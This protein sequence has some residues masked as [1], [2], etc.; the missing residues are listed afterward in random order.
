L[1]DEY[2]QDLKMAE[3]GAL[4]EKAEVDAIVAAPVPGPV[5]VPVATVGEK[6]KKDYSNIRCENSCWLGRC[7]Y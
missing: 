1:T 7:S 2:W 5:E 4:V 3:V 6:R